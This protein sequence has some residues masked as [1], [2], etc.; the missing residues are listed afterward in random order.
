MTKEEYLMKKLELE[1]RKVKALETIA[2]AVYLA[3]DHN[4][5]KFLSDIGYSMANPHDPNP[6]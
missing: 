2:K 3:D 1:E 6:N 4:V 5:L